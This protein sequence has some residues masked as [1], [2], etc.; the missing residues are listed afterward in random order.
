[1]PSR[2]PF[3]ADSFITTISPC[4]KSVS[5]PLFRNLP[6][7]GFPG[8]MAM[9]FFPL[10]TIKTAHACFYHNIDKFRKEKKIQENIILIIQT[11]GGNHG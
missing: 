3:Q 9:G 5:D 6:A 11:F 2:G 8:Q 7:L 1:M 4:R 10:L